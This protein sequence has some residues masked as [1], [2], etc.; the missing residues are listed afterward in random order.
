MIQGNKEKLLPA[1]HFTIEETLAN[2]F[3]QAPKNIDENSNENAFDQEIGDIETI[4]EE[5]SSVTF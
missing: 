4:S 1:K 2:Y 5:K 3:D